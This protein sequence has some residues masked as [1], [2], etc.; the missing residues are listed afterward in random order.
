MKKCPYC[1]E[2]IQDEAIKCKHCG[3]MLNAPKKGQAG[4]G[5]R[6]VK[7]GIKRVEL[8]KTQYEISIF[9]YLIFGVIVGWIAGSIWGSGWGWFIGIA[10]VLY[11][12]VKSAR[13][14]YE[15][16]KDK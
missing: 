13:S 16:D 2:D 15:M 1:A 9:F 8:D 4:V 5:Y 11:F 14:Y 7:K 6:E 10:T 12:G 3:E